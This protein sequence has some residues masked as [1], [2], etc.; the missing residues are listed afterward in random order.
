M[1]APFLPVERVFLK[2][3]NSF[4]KAATAFIPRV[5]LKGVKRVQESWHGLQVSACKYELISKNIFYFTR[6]IFESS[7]DFQVPPFLM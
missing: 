1:C 7:N 3:P 6:I 4:P 2:S 5:R